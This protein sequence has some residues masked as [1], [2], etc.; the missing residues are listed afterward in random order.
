[1]KT[2]RILSCALASI[3]AFTFVAC[4]A[5]TSRDES[6]IVAIG[7]VHGDLQATRAAL[8]LAGAID[9]QDHWV[10]GN[11]TV[12]Q[13]GDQLDR[14]EDEQA[15][16]DLFDALGEEAAAA[17]G[18]FYPLLGNHELMNAKGDLRYVTEGGSRT[19]RMWATMIRRTLFWPPTNRISEPAWP[20][21]YQAGHMP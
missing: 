19:S 10:G 21:C 8:R 18:A 9:E 15:I 2:M 16:L 14:G 7:D 3:L 4:S 11:L 20:P 5:S 6:R 12:V 13:T 1:M 17:G